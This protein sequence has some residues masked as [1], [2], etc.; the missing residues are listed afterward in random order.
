MDDALVYSAEFEEHLQY[1]RTSLRLLKEKGIKLKPEKCKLF[2]QEVK[3]L[4]HIITAKG[5]KMDY[6]DK[7]AVLALKGKLPQTIGEARTLLGFLGYFRKFIPNFS[8]RAKDLYQL[9]ETKFVKTARAADLQHQDH[10][11]R[12]PHGRSGRPGGLPHFRTHHGLP[13][14]Q[15]GVHPA[16]GRL[17]GSSRGGALS[18]AG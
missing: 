1:L 15:Q 18:A 9:L 14:F 17:A 2:R 3:F 12:R 7:E 5:Y 4:G 8:C 11:D 6:A 16:H 10:L 13:V